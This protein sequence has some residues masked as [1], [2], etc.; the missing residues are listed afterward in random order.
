MIIARPN[1]SEYYRTAALPSFGMALE[2]REDLTPSSHRFYANMNRRI[3]SGGVEMVFEDRI[4]LFI[5]RGDMTG[6]SGDATPVLVV[7]FT[8][9][10]FLI[11]ELEAKR[12]QRMQYRAV[13]SGDP[14]RVEMWQPFNFEVVR[15]V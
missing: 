4:A 10:E 15:E 6:V 12:Y 9:D 11:G 13:A 1:R 8:S 3:A 5:R 14:T 2:G 7:N